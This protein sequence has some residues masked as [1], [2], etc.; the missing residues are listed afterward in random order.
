M[1][2]ALRSTADAKQ[3]SHCVYLQPVVLN[4][5]TFINHHYYLQKGLFLVQAFTRQYP[6]TPPRGSGL[7]PDRSMW[8]LWLMKRQGTGS[9]QSTSGFSCQSHPTNAP[10]LF[11]SLIYIYMYV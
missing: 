4:V 6:P 2:R 8:N 3:N 10:D 11:L 5:H 9:S 1:Y 7:S